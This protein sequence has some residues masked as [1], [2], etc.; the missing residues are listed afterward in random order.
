MKLLSIISFLFAFGTFAQEL[1]CNVQVILSQ[2]VQTAAVDKSVFSSLESQVREFMNNRKWTNDNFKVEERIECQIAITINEAPSVDQFKCGIQVVSARPVYGSS[3]KTTLL[4]FNDQNFD[5]QFL[6]GTRLEWSIDQHRSNLTSVLAYY[7]YMILGYDYDSYSLE[8]GTEYFTKAQQ[9]VSNAANAPQ[10]GWK[11]NE[12][13][14]NRYWLVENALHQAFK[15]LRRCYYEYHK[16]GFDA[17]AANVTQ[18]RAQVTKSINYINQVLTSRPGSINIQ[19]FFRAK[20]DELYNLYSQAFPQ[21]KN[22]VVPIFKKGDPVNT[23]LYDKI[24]KGK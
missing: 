6:R 16:K 23:E 13:V 3:Y 19:A 9:I 21:E 4:N 12:S 2:N 8:G 15:P 17:M 22:K 14:N 24:I 11:A 18:G 7:A 5:I 1:N 10:S 20:S